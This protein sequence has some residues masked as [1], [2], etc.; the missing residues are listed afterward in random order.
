[1]SQLESAPSDAGPLTGSLLANRYELGALLGKGG[2]GHVYT[3]RD[4]KLQREVAVKLLS[5]ASPGAD[6][7][8]RF[9][10]EALAT[11]SLQHPNIV[12]VFDVGED[13]GRPYLV[14]E[15]LRGATL[16]ALLER[17]PLPAERAQGFA[18]QIAAGLAAAH[19]K[20]FTHRDLKPANIF[21]TGD[22]WLKILDFGLVKLGEALQHDPDSHR[23]V[24]TLGYMAPEQVRGLPVDA[25]ADLFNFGLVLYEMLAGKRAFEGISSTETSYAIVVRSPPPLPRT[26]PRGLRELVRRCLAKDRENRPRSAQEVARLLD[27]PPP[28]P[29]RAWMG[30]AALLVLAAAAA[31]LWPR[32][33]Q[34]PLAGTVAVFPFDAREVR[35][36]A[37]LAKNLDHLLGL[38]LAGTALAPIDDARVHAAAKDEPAASVAERRRQM[39][40]KL[41]ARYFVA[42]SAAERGGELW[43][44]ASLRETRSS[45]ELAHGEAHGKPE[46]ILRLVRA[47]SDELQ[48]RKRTPEEFEARLR[49]FRQ[50]NTASVPALEAWLEA[51][52]L[53]WFSAEADKATELFQRAIALDPDYTRALFSFGRLLIVTDQDRSEQLLARALQHPERLSFDERIHGQN[54]LLRL[55]G[56]LDQATRLLYDAAREHPEDPQIWRHIGAFIFNR[57]P[58]LGRSPQEAVDAFTRQAELDPLDIEPLGK[59][60]HL[61]VLR[62]EREVALQIVDHILNVSDPEDRSIS[63]TN[64]LQLTRA[65]AARDEDQRRKVMAAYKAQQVSPFVALMGINRIAA[66]MDGSPDAV[67]LASLIPLTDSLLRF[68]PGFTPLASA[69]LLRGHVRDARRAMAEAIAS[70]PG[71]DRDLYLPWIDTV[72]LVAPAAKELASSRASAAALDVAADPARAPAKH[73][74]IGLLAVR[75]RDLGAAEAAV[76]ALQALPE[77]PRS[78]IAADLALALQARILAAR[79]DAK[80]A[81]A[82]FDRQRLRIPER[83]F[84]LYGRPRENFFRASLLVAV[85]RPREALTLYEALSPYD[86]VDPTFYP[87]GQLYAARVYDSLGEAQNAARHYQR[88]IEMWRDC[89]PEERPEVLRARTR[90]LELAAAK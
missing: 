11:G 88:F 79:G 25:R 40:L 62:G 27:A 17:G 64:H 42:G 52:R 37:L 56:E 38:D 33:A 67:E 83:F 76:R 54:Y 24:G 5:S 71:G 59:L 15:L 78:T 51:Y 4:R 60:S 57:G 10:R 69:N 26:L 8:R 35:E 22:G 36:S 89:D 55:R 72:E 65:W 49:E 7:M 87:A 77:I 44:S 1:V 29:K 75:A 16:R 84:H 58:L 41:N 19:D 48:N 74:L 20:G 61:A 80:A 70:H 32:P 28:R 81:L 73:Y 86:L 45:R 31:A 2:A 63:D 18:R 9:S 50:A 13:Q 3:A 66:Q 30:A 53:T 6:A 14:T 82:V 47:L 90:L 21:I 68:E 46:A 12:A 34:V 39:A 23:I 43:I 85:G